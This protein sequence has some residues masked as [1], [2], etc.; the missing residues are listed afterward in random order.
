LLYPVLGDHPTISKYSEKPVK[1]EDTQEHVEHI[2]DYHG[3]SSI[4]DIDTSGCM[5]YCCYCLYGR[6]RGW[7]A[8]S[9]V[10]LAGHH[11]STSP[12]GNVGM[13]SKHWL[14]R[15]SLE[16]LPHMDLVS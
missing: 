11:E 5:A 15:I 9:L 3:L 14:G 1:S 12:S 6:L 7:E 10:S 4:E 13:G 2:I 16:M 8:F